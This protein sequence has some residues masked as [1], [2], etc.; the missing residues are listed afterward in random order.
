[1]ESELEEKNGPF[2]FHHIVNTLLHFNLAYC[3]FAGE[4]PDTP[5]DKYPLQTLFALKLLSFLYDFK[6]AYDH[7]DCIE[8]IRGF[9][10]SAVT[11]VCLYGFRTS[12]HTLNIVASL[13]Y[14]FLTMIISLAIA[15]TFSNN[16]AKGYQV[17]VVC[18]VKGLNYV[19]K[20]L[21]L[22]LFWMALKGDVGWFM[23]CLPMI[24]GC[25]LLIILALVNLFLAL[26]IRNK[27]K[28]MPLFFLL[29]G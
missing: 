11:A 22:L 18:T 29:F 1:M 9:I 23:A 2:V 24:M 5:Q 12:N 15:A 16:A 7:R 28:S 4:S 17:V 6:Y 14:I 25:A 3:F 20:G 21:F 10:C 13:V 27:D 8:L 19:F 26:R